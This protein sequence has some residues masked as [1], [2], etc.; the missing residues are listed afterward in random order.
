MRSDDQIGKSLN[1]EPLPDFNHEAGSQWYAIQTR[2]RNEKWVATRL[3][4]QGVPTFLPLV[5]EIHRWSDRRK[6]VEVPLF[7]CYV[8]VRLLPTIEQRLRV[9]R[10]NGVINFVGVGWEGT[11]VPDEQIDAI[12][13]LLAEKLPWCTHPFVK[14]GQRVRIRGGAMDGVEGVLVSRNGDRTLVLSIDAIQRSLAIRI[15][16]YDFEPA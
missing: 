5:A 13:S 3:E 12:R 9:L 11:S 2:A 8:F 14:I 7:S 6:S 16:G 15:D 4:S 1:S 10:L